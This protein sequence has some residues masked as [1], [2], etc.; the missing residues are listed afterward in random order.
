MSA[1]VIGKG[2]TK[3][4]LARSDPIVAREQEPGVSKRMRA[5]SLPKV[6]VRLRWNWLRLRDNADD[7]G[8]RLEELRRHDRVGM[9]G[10][11]PPAKSWTVCCSPQPTV[12]RITPQIARYGRV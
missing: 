8:H 4:G 11:K 6:P 1:D 10:P 12:P 7:V 9:A 5:Q 2:G 3:Q